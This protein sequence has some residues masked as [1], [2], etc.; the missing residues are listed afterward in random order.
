VYNHSS[1][2]MPLDIKLP[3]AMLHRSAFGE[4]L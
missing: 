3:F 1:L 2:P 4:K